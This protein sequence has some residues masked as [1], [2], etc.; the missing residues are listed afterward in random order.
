MPRSRHIL[1]ILV[2]IAIITTGFY[3]SYDTT[4]DRPSIVRH[5]QAKVMVPIVVPNPMTT[6]PEQEQYIT[7]LPH[8]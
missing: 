2:V 4:L 5:D 1:A 3:L 7:Y 8:R 6:R